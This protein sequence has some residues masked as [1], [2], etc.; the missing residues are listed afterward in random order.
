MG[1]E[2]TGGE[3]SIQ[4]S[5]RRQIRADFDAGNISSDGGVLLLKAA[6]DRAKILEQFAACFTDHRDPTRIEH[7]V[8][9]LVTQRAF[10]LAL[11]YED[12]ND[13]DEL[14]LDPLLAA[15]IGKKDPEGAGRRHPCG[16]GASLAASSTLNRLELARRG[17]AATH[18]YKRI[19]LD[20]GAVDDLFV[21]LFVQA[22]EKT[23]AQIVLDFDA[24][25]D[26]LH[27]NQEGRFF[28]GYY[29]HFCYLP[30]YVFCGDHLLTAR[31]R[32]SNI[33]G[34]AGTVEELQ[35]L[36][37]SIRGYWPEVKILVRGDS[38][39]CRENIMKWCE[40]HDVDFIFGLAKNK[41][42]KKRITRQLRKAERKCIVTG[43]PA[44]FFKE[45]RYK[46]KKSWSR[47]RRVVAKAEHLPQGSNPRFVVTSLTR[48]EADSADLYEKLYC[49]RGDMEN[50]IKEQ[51]L[52]CFAD[53]T[54]AHEMRANQIRLYFS[55]I[56][57]TLLECIRRI[58]LRAT[59]LA[60]AQCNTI[61][62]KLL[63]IGAIVR[64]TVRKVW[65]SMSSAFPR[66]ELFRV[67]LENLRT[68]PG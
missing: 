1:T 65:V 21:N 16:R 68:S 18:R 48:E 43:Q 2:C 37:S 62:T 49:A 47:T 22:F 20:E 53:R 54:S 41:R 5:G 33:D 46:T 55:S 15:A 64:V 50:R 32:P 40:E 13:H 38:G 7:T 31:L 9:D 58:G 19:E 39:F 44:R 14:R 23:P 29:G 67:V 17:D 30:L 63:K 57:Y 12:L 8:R 36:V 34:A 4:C 59:D 26:P 25:D 61:R 10:G 66:A 6:D 24:T 42:L 35:R 28:H 51:Q 11:G 3:I 56:A 60:R 27:G 45:L 52:F